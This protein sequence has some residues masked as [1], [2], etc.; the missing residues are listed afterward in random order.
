[1]C[2]C[3]VYLMKLYSQDSSVEMQCGNNKKKNMFLFQE[4]NLKSTR[5]PQIYKEKWVCNP[6]EK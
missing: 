5:V 1:M 6:P 4:N 3:F 2:N